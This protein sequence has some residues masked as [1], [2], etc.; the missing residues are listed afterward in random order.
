MARKPQDFVTAQP[1]QAPTPS[2]A[3]APAATPGP[4]PMHA[5]SPTPHPSILANRQRY[6]VDQNGNASAGMPAGAGPDHLRRAVVTNDPQFRIAAAIKRNKVESDHLPKPGKFSAMLDATPTPEL[7][8]P[9]PEKV[10]SWSMVGLQRQPNG[11]YTVHAWY[12]TGD[13]KTK[14]TVWKNLTPLAARE[15]HAMLL[16]AVWAKL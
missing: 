11:R 2:P 12:Y 7:R 13:E 9:A 8:T 16:A 14:E 1:E 4:E 5:L 6:I 15:R 3:P 10:V